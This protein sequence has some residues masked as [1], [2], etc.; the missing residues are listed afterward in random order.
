MFMLLW[1]W[2]FVLVVCGLGMLWGAEKLCEVMNDFRKKWGISAA[3][4]GGILAFASTSPEVIMNLS[5]AILGK[6]S[7]GLG[8]TLGSNIL[9]IPILTLVGF[10]AAKKHLDM[11]LQVEKETVYSHAIPYLLIIFL[12]AFLTL[13]PEM[14]LE[15][16]D[17]IILVLAYLIYLAYTFWR[18]KG[19][20]QEVV[21]PRQETVFAVIGL[22]V[23]IV[24]AYLAIV[25]TERISHILGLSDLVSGLFI[26]AAASSSPEAIA[27]WHAVKKGEDVAAATSVIDDN[28]VS[29]TLAILPVSFLV[30]IENPMIF[31]ISLL[32]VLITSI[33]YI[34]FSYT[35][36]KFNWIEIIAFIIT[37]IIYGYLI[38]KIGII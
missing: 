32:F 3:F 11:D 37:Y 10:I 13:Y 23:L 34:I 31:L 7:I 26:A 15:L 29:L 17:G 1:F 36:K 21:I 38:L 8:N 16:I 28:I 22:F 33:E 5:S 24:S 35:S 25:S 19:E 18:G 4:A 20:G 14:G 9:N 27:A 30:E 12:F 6:S 2:V